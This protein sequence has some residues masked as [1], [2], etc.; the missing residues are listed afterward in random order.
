[1][2]EMTPLSQRALVAAVAV[3]LAAP[4]SVFV[5]QPGFDK[6][7]SLGLDWDYV[8]VM[9]W[10]FAASWIVGGVLAWF[11]RKQRVRYLIIQGLLS[12]L[13]AFALWCGYAYYLK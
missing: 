13:F 5:L 4:L 11:C 2:A 9:F 1:M 7:N 12:P 3:E 6:P 8:V 10:V